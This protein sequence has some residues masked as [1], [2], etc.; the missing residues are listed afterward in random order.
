MNALIIQLISVGAIVAIAGLLLL[1][2]PI[3]ITTKNLAIATMLVVLSV[4]LQFFSIMIPLFGFPSFRIDFLQLP[5]MILGVYLGPMWGLLGGLLQDFLGLIITP[6]NYPFLGFTL[7]K[8]LIGVIPGLVFLINKKQANKDIK[9]SLL[10]LLS[11]FVFG[12]IVYLFQSNS[13]VVNQQVVVIESWMKYGMTGLILLLFGGLVWVIV[14]PPLAMQKQ[15]ISISHWMFA[16][17][18]V[19]IVVH[20]ILTPIW[21]VT[22][23]QIPV[24][25]SFLLRV[26]KAA[27]MIPLMIGIGYGL[28]VYIEKLSKRR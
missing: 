6:T 11:L 22:M 27:V 15:H 18:L 26:I 3:K 17:I 13:I 19:E 8:V 21:L 20:L 12:A 16:V 28:L 14:K 25:I 9:P 4:V 7:N 23:Y 5:L 1:L 2:D 10:G 24:L